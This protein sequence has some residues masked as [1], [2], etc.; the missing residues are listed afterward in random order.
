MANG[1]PLRLVHAAEESRALK[2]F[3]G[4]C[5]ASPEDDFSGS[6]RSRVCASCGMGV[7]LEASEDTVPKPA[8]AFLV[9]DSAMYVRAVSRRCE[10][11]LGVSEPD[12]VD[13][14]IG[15]LLEPADTAPRAESIH[16]LILLAATG[17]SEPQTVAVRPAGEFGIRHW[18][19]ISTCGSPSAALL[20]LSD[21]DSTATG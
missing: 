4:H 8:D 10:R 17:R 1:R 19:R 14:R 15:E 20:V 5:A 18:A 21:M 12:A 9:V 16:A 13:R 3:C 7:V 11:L 6:P 2:G